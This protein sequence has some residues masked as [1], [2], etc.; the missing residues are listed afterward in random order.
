MLIQ[1]HRNSSA[2]AF[3]DLVAK[4]LQT[5]YDDEVSQ[6]RVYRIW[7]SDPKW[8]GFPSFRFSNGFYLEFSNGYEE[9]TLKIRPE[10]DLVFSLSLMG[11]L[12]YQY[13]S[14]T[15]SFPSYFI[16]FDVDNNVIDFE[17]AYECRNEL[18]FDID[19]ILDIDQKRFFA[20]VNQFKSPNPLKVHSARSLTSAHFHRSATVLQI[21]RLYNP[22]PDKF[23]DLVTVRVPKIMA[24][25]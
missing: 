11:G 2:F 6:T 23:R 9:N 25:L 7:P 10:F 15:L 16:P 19:N 4:I 17:K 21:S 14:G 5:H 8:I 12:K 20:A 22:T 18:N 1:N 3:F 24:R 13:P